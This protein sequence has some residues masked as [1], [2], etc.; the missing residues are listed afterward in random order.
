MPGP[1]TARHTLTMA[2]PT[3]EMP[4]TRQW[5]LT[6]ERQMAFNSTVRVSYTGTQG[7][8]AAPL[9]AGQPPRLAADRTGSGR[10][11]SQQ[12]PGGRLPR[13]ARPHDQSR[14]PPTC[15]C[16]GTGLPGIT[17]NAQCPVAVP[18][19]DNEISF[20][21]PRTNER[22]PDP[23]Y[24]TN[25]LVSNNAESWYHGLQI[26]WTRRYANGL[27]FQ[28]S[29]TWSKREDTTSEATF[30]GAGDSN[31]LGPN[32]R[33]RAGPLRFHT[34]HRFTFN[35]SYRL[36]FLRDRPDALGSIARRLDAL[37][38]R[39]ARARHAV[40]RHRWRRPRSQLRWLHREPADPPRPNRCSDGTVADPDT[41]R[42]ILSRDK[43]RTA[44][45]GEDNHIVGRNTFFGDG[46]ETVDLGIYKTFRFPWRHDLIVRF[47]AYNAFNKVQYGFPTSTS[48]APPSARSPV[49]PYTYAPRTLQLAVR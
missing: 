19:A 33:F 28:T 39:P 20:R 36:P 30:V 48:A 8:R 18:I 6:V 44:Q 10:G 11:P 35:G 21:V 5:N 38:D 9:P 14:L 16:A 34:P 13:P 49:A 31:Q 25:L 26:E 17:V 12:C 37:G 41:S 46:L 27:W 15:Q 40:H 29:Y 23:R 32:A 47:E 1:Q 24:T 2:D 7:Q 22:R 45:F 43:F 4:R 42:T 3:L